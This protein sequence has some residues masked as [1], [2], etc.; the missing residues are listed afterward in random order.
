MLG[1]I[2]AGEEEDGYVL[3]R[4]TRDIEKK[5][6]YKEEVNASKTKMV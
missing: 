2:P 5:R 4:G 3:E 1:S 6:T